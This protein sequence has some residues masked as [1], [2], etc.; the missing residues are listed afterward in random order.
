MLEKVGEDPVIKMDTPAGL[1]TAVA[2]REGKRVKDVSFQNVPSFVYLENQT[3]EVP[4]L[5]QVRYDLAFGGAF[6]AFVEA[7]NL[8]V[9]L[10]PED[11]H[12]LI[13]V[14]MRVKAAVMDSV[15]I[16][17]PFEE[18]LGFLYGTIIV[19]KALDPEHHSR[20]VCIFANGEVDRSPTGTGVS[21]RAAIHYSRGDL[22]LGD[23]FTVESIIGTC[24]TGKV[25]AATRFGP[26]GA[27]VPEVTGSA[28][29]VGR[30]EWLLDPRD[31]L[32]EGFI[33]R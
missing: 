4:E 19:G 15:P 30:C 3:V 7:E 27:V 2:H 23:S 26:F 10:N 24:F 31:P 21:A 11:F 1:V 22:S 28:H 29:I 9:S 20:N 33:L 6:Y 18:D 12:R 5:G 8:G 25:A 17:H 32:R 16:R 14:G 13:D